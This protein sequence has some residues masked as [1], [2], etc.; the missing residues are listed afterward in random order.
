MPGAGFVYRKSLNQFLILPM[1][2]PFEMP[3]KVRSAHGINESFRSYIQP[4]AKC[5]GFLCGKFSRKIIHK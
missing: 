5:F 4:D 1:C 2:N 3:G